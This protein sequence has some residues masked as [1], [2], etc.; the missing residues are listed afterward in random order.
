MEKA[1]ILKP[2]KREKY[3]HREFTSGKI[4]SKHFQKYGRIE[5]RAKHPAGRGLWPAIWMMPQEKSKSTGSR[6]E[7]DLFDRKYSC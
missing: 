5:V 1:K 3:E 2:I 7:I 4:T 6:T